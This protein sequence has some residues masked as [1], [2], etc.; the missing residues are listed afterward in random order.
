MM[1]SQSSDSRSHY[2]GRVIAV[3]GPPH[4][5]KSVFLA[6][7]YQKL[8]QRQSTG[9]FLQR[10]CPDGEG[11]W[12]NEADPAIVKTIRKKFAFSEEF[13]TLTLKA[14]E[15][16]GRN[17][18]LSL[19]LLD[20]GGKRTAENAEIL[21]RSTHCILLSAGEEESAY[22]HTFAAAEDCPVLATFQSRLVKLP[23]QQ[24][25]QSARSSIQTNLPT[26]QGTFVNLSRDIGPCCYEAAIAQF[27]VWLN[28]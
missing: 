2:S 19:V 5:G 1:P 12:S 6:A 17:P 24:L 26:P 3:C 9:I 8:L 7:L 16:L 25:D 23:N 13:V 21:R 18:Q 10:A 11:M 28:P 22:W 27:A 15:Q 14:I 4:S 20:L